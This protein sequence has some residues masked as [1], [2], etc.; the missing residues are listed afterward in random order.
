MDKMTSRLV[1]AALV[2]GLAVLSAGCAA[3]AAAPAGGHPSAAAAGSTALPNP[4]T[5]LARYGVKP[6]GLRSDTCIA[7]SP[8]RAN[9]VI[10]PGAR[11]AAA[12]LSS[13]T[14]ARAVPVRAIAATTANAPVHPLR[15]LEPNPVDAQKPWPW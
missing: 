9:T 6:L 13:S 4:F 12:G 5:V 15:M 1:A 10:W 11:E 8:P 7:P 14:S 3:N 2:G